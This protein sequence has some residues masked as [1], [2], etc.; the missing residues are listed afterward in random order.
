MQGKGQGG[1]R[2]R[3]PAS[4]SVWEY[5]EGRGDGGATGRKVGGVGMPWGGKGRNVG[6]GERRAT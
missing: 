4:S 5:W 3:L 2:G 1:R 6:E